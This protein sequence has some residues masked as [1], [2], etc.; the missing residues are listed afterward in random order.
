[1]T[2]LNKKSKFGKLAKECKT[3][4]QKID[5]FNTYQEAFV[6]NRTNVTFSLRDN[7]SKEID[8][9]FYVYANMKRMTENE[10]NELRELAWKN[11][12]TNFKIFL[13]DFCFPE[14]ELSEL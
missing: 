8:D 1:M 14:Y 3:D 4:I 5:F 11:Y 9:A 7:V 13:F 6:P 12:P 10:L 2:Q